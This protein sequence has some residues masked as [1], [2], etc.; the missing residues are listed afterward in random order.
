MAIQ[1]II[2]VF[3]LS[4]NEGNNDWEKVKGLDDMGGNSGSGF[5]T[6]FVTLGK[7]LPPTVSRPMCT[8]VTVRR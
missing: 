1:I 8:Y 4:V 3:E 6:G 7:S 2:F 5:A